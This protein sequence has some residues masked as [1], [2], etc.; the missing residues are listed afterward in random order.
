MTATTTTATGTFQVTMASPNAL[1]IVAGALLILGALIFFFL[2]IRLSRAREDTVGLLY[3]LTG[4]FWVL[5]SIFH[6]IFMF[7]AGD[8]RNAIVFVEEVFLLLSF[9]S[10]SLTVFHLRRKVLPITP[11]SPPELKGKQ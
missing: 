1:A 3:L 2:A 11:V 8:S 9:I 4:I 10:L 6:F 5:A 7:L